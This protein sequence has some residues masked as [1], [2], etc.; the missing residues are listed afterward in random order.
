M[1]DLKKRILAIA[2]TLAA[3]VTFVL[4]AVSCSKSEGASRGGYV[5]AA[6]KAS[7][8]EYEMIPL[9]KNYA[10]YK[11]DGHINVL[12]LVC[13]TYAEYFPNSHAVWAPLL[14]EYDI[15]IDLLGPPTYS[16]ESLLSTLESSLQSGKYDIVVLYPITPQAITPYLDIAW[17]T[18]K[19]P[20]LAYAFSPDTECGHYYLGTSYYEAGVTLGHAIIEYVN[21]NSAYYS[22]I[23]NYSRG[24][25]YADRGYRAIPPYQ[26]R[27]GHS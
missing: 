21:D 20:I 26:W 15:S 7:A 10:Q 14:A 27:V 8:D 11:Y 23:K 24:D 3:A 22:N 2:L 1:K 12:Y 4:F 5:R 25:L 13:T 6:A 9:L 19:V 18:Y 16:D 17:D